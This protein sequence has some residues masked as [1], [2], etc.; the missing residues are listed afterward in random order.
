LRHVG[1]ELELVSAEPQHV[2][3]DARH[4]VDAPVRRVV[5]DLLI[6][7]GELRAHALDQLERE[8][9]HLSGDRSRLAVASAAPRGLERTAQRAPAAI[10][11]MP[12][13]TSPATYSKCGV[14]PRITHPSVITPA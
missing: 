12:F 4:A 14:P 3:V 11:P 2:A 13:E 8:L 5:L 9:L 7:L 6:E 1:A 10:A